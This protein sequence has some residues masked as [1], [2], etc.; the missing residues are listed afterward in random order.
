MT[1]LYDDDI[2]FFDEDDVVDL[3]SLGAETVATLDSLM[4]FVGRNVIAG[5]EKVAA[6]RRL[7]GLIASGERPSPATIEGFALRTGKREKVARQ[8]RTVYEGLLAGKG[9]RDH[10]GRPI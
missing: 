3:G 9:F 10:G 2:G 5:K 6:V 1:D 4:F 8:L 7:R